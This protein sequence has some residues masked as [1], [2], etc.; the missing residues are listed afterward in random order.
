MAWS[1]ALVTMLEVLNPELHADAMY[2]LAN[3]M[4][5]RLKICFFSWSS[6]SQMSKEVIVFR[7]LVARPKF[8]GWM[9][10]T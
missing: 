7:M 2:L 8:P 6:L 5:W 3:L 4:Y 9:M 1:I 10:L